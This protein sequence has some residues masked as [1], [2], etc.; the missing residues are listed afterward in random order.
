M[1]KRGDSER[2]RGWRPAAARGESSTMRRENT[3]GLRSATAA[4]LALMVGLL[5]L[6]V[7]APAALADAT[8]ITSIAMGELG[9]NNSPG[10]GESPAGSGCNKYTGALYGATPGCA[11]GYGNKGAWRSWAWCADYAT[12]VWKQAGVDIGGLTSAVSSF[13]AYG[14]AH[15]TYHA[16]GSGY[17]PQP[18]DAAVYGSAHV[19]IVV[20]TGKPW[21]DVV[22]GNLLV[23]GNWQVYLQPDSHD[24]NA[25]RGGAALTGFV[26]PVGG[27]SGGG[28]RTGRVLGSSCRDFHT[29]PNSGT[30]GLGCIP[31]GATIAIECVKNGQAVSGP[32]GT[33][34]VWDRTTYGGQLGFISDSWVYTG[35]NSAVAP[36]CG[37]NGVVLTAGCQSVYSAPSTS[38]NAV[39]CIP[40]ATAVAVDC[41][42]AGDAIGGPFGTESV[43]D[44]TSYGGTG[45]VPDADIYTG[46]NN[47]IAGPCPSIPQPPVALGGT[48]PPAGLNRSYS[49]TLKGSGG[50][51]AY[52]WSVQRG[53]LPDG[54]SLADSGVLSGTPR[55]AGRFTFG[56][57]VA[58]GIGLV[59]TANETLTV[60]APAHNVT[61]AHR[62]S[63][64]TV[65]YGGPVTVST[66]ATD[67]SAGKALASARVY[68]QRRSG[69]SWVNI[70]E[71]R[72]GPTG[73]ATYTFAPRVSQTLRWY[74][75]AWTIG[76]VNYRTAAS[77]AFTVK[78][79]V[80]HGAVT[81]TGTPRVGQ[82]LTAHPG[83][84]SPSGVSF[85]Y[86]WYAGAT[87]IRGGIH[88]RLRLTTSQ[89]GKVVRVHVRGV[90]SGDVA[91]TASSAAS[92]R[93]TR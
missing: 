48:L 75:R 33:E 56:V 49:A 59:G 90:R 77:G 24:N 20:S 40:E 63:H 15:Q 37:G 84:W 50:T 7:A 16:V 42:A 76:T 69:G 12:W 60:T 14:N 55:A 34:T 32:Y 58:D 80:R 36:D 62:L 70:R 11:A 5:G 29:A 10:H 52:S 72:T 61:L 57:Q 25:N 31:N 64:G 38:S 51:G 2:R 67:A 17:T 66:T 41:V 35:T 39:S 46:T 93:V 44:H 91:V 1:R 73:S 86:Q 79:A 65:T 43:W 47:A 21:P 28:P 83:T 71:V 89:V 30:P 74:V 19:G 85:S 9:P 87:A 22:S 8:S 78:V 27:T 4:I 53:A 88:S 26:T 54:L 18:G 81:V 92:K 23:N 68:L 13:T 6:T 82:T 3:T 45:F